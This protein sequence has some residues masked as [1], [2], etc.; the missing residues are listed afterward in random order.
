MVTIWRARD[1]VIPLSLQVVTTLW[2]AHS[3]RYWPKR[4]S[5]TSPC[6][7]HQPPGDPIRVRVAL[8]LGFVSYHGTTHAVQQPR[9]GQVG[10][11]G[12]G[13]WD[14]EF[15]GKEHGQAL[16]LEVLGAPDGF[17]VTKKLLHQTK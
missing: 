14:L 12:P 6:H 17:Y 1:L 11:A 15:R 2:G 13:P 16:C 9:R 8:N 10:R 5:S 7:Q 4:S 3:A